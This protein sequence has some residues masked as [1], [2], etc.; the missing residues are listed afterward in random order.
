MATVNVVPP[1]SQV[2]KDDEA[3]TAVLEKINQIEQKIL[4][5]SF[6]YALVIPCVTSPETG[7]MSIKLARSGLFSVDS[8]LL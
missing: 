7:S 2:E 4:F 3:I 5:N 1:S 6:A 8:S